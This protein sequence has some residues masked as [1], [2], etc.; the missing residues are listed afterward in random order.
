M[1]RHIRRY[2]ANS[3]DG[4]LANFCITIRIMIFL[5]ALSIFKCRHFTGKKTITPYD[6][7]WRNLL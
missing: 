5:S 3:T 1:S 2:F 4:E 7:N 6:E